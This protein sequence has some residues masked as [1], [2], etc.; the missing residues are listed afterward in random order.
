VSVNSAIQVDLMGQV[1]AEMIGGQQFSGIGGQVD[2]IRGAGRSL[3]GKSIIAL[4]ST[5]SGGQVSRICCQL[6]RGAAVSTSRNDVHYIVTEYG[7]AELRGKSIRQRALDLINI[8]HPKF[9]ELLT[10]QANVEGLL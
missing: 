3:G 5:A 7:T 6:D 10:R 4:P 9:R 8:S 1:N 2:F